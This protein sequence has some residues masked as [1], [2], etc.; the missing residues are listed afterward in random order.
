[1]DGVSATLISFECSGVA[2]FCTLSIK[3]DVCLNGV[4]V[5]MGS[6]YKKDEVVLQK[7]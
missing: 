4:H 7:L 1:M 3:G 6:M 5:A 2:M